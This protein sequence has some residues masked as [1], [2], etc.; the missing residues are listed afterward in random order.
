[1]QA[2]RF[3]CSSA[4]ELGIPFAIT[5]DFQTVKDNT[6]TL[7]ERDTTKPQ[8]RTSVRT[9]L[10]YQTRSSWMLSLVNLVFDAVARRAAGRAAGTGGQARQRRDLLAKGGGQL[11]APHCAGMTS[12]KIRG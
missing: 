11:P 10:A 3:P 5:V 8:I 12:S 6:A 1:M 4:D 7:R 9:R 2:T